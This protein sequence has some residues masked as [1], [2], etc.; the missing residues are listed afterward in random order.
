MR[1]CVC[2]CVCP[3]RV[4][5]ASHVCRFSHPL[6]LPL[7]LGFVLFPFWRQRLEPSIEIFSDSNL[8]SFFYEIVYDVASIIDYSKKP[9]NAGVVDSPPPKKICQRSPSPS[10]LKGIEH[11]GFRAP[12]SRPVSVVAPQR[13]LRMEA[14][15]AKSGPLHILLRDALPV[16]AN[17]DASAPRAKVLPRNSTL[18]FYLKKVRVI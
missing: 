6:S 7:P 12:P 4:I 11:N 18:S 15:P 5:Y 17:S 10:P 8:G 3:L 14:R 1:E 16:Q 2:A 13:R 9:L